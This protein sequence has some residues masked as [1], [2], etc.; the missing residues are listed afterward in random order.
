MTKFEIKRAECME[1]N[2]MTINN[3]PVAGQTYPSKN[4][5]GLR[6]W[7]K[8]GLLGFAV[9][10]AGLCGFGAIYQSFASRADQRT[11]LPPG[12]FVDLDG[13]R[14]HLL[15][16]RKETGKPTILLEAG[17]GSFSSNWAWVQRELAASTRV[18]ASDRAGLGWSDPPPEPQDGFESAHD[19][20]TALEKAGIS[21]PYVVVG[22][23]YGG[24]VVRAF[25]D[26]Y[27]Q[28]VVGMVLVDAS[29]PD[30]WAQIPESRGGRTVSVGN[31]I[32]GF[33]TGLG[34][35]RLFDMNASLTAGL[36]DRQA[37]ELKAA[38]NRSQA[39]S[40]SSDVLSI[41]EKRTRPKINAAQSLGNLPLAV[42]SVT[43][44]AIYSEV[45]TELQAE[46]P[47]L[48]SNSL[49]RTIE[50]A[51]HED[52][53]SQREHALQVVGVI[54]QVLESAQSGMPLLPE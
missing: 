41:W 28:E 10:V 19:L 8:R 20:H 2:R 17:I 52:L 46:L 11:Y 27:P 44:Q 33:L 9:A 25:A 12:E 42:L 26:L 1:K 15:V 30:Q 35:V 53:V 21:G 23:S 22:H 50:G 47:A 14:M 4:R 18:V 24:L 6:I 51:T 54:L 43:E 29:H 34:I 40:T 31:R 7:L 16:M 48:S 39:W 5:R 38:L 36:P 3:F 45:L 32:T 49:H 37:A 13:R